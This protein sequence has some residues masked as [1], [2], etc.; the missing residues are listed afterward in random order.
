MQSEG[1]HL[2]SLSLHLT[3]HQST[4]LCLPCLLVF[5]A[6]SFSFQAAQLVFISSVCRECKQYGDITGIKQ[7]DDSLGTLMKTSTF[8]GG[9]G[10]T[11]FNNSEKFFW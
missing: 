6:T 11:S 5:L 2:S 1:A 3:P 9:G 4:H 7:A 8:G 10:M